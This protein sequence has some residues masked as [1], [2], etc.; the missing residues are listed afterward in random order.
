MILNKEDIEDIYPASYLQQGMIVEYFKNQSYHMINNQLIKQEYDKDKFLEIFRSLVDKHSVLRNSFLIND[1]YGYLNVQHKQIDLENKIHYLTESSCLEKVL[2]EPIDITVAGLYRLIILDN[3]D[4]FEFYFVNH[5]AIEDGWSVASLMSEFINCYINNELAKEEIIP[6]YAKYIAKELSCYNSD[7]HKEFWKNYLSNYEQVNQNLI[8]N[9]KEKSLDDHIVVSRNLNKSLSKNLIKL[10]NS[11]NV[12]IDTIFLMVYQYVLCKLFNID[13]LVTGVT[14]NNRLEEEGGDKV[15]G[16]H[17]NVVPVRFKLDFN[18]TFKA[19]ILSVLDNK[20]LVDKYKLY[21]YGKIKSDLRLEEDIYKCGFNYTHFHIAGNLEQSERGLKVLGYT[22]IPLIFN[23]SRAENLL[24]IS[25]EGASNYID[26]QTINRLVGYIFDLL[27]NLA[28]YKDK[29]LIEYQLLNKE[30]YK[31]IVY[32]WN[33]TDREYP[34]DKTIYELFEEQVEQNPNNVALVYEGQQLTYKELNEKSNQLAR[35]IRK[36]YKEITNQDLVADTLIPLCLDRSL[37]MV[38]G[39]LG[40]MKA[41]GAYVPMDPDYPEERFRHILSDT[42][43]KMVVT[44][45]HL[46]DKLGYIASDINLISIDLD[47][48]QNYVY[49]QEDKSNLE[50]QSKSTDLAYVIYTSGTTGLPKGVLQ[51]HENVHRLLS[52]TDHQFNFNSNDVWTLYHSYIFDFTVWELWGSLIYGGKLIIPSKEIVKDICKFVELCSEYKVSVLNQTPSAFYTFIDQLDSKGNINI[53]RLRYV[54]FGGDALNV[55]HLSKWWTY[56]ESKNFQT[57]LINMYGITE[58]TV[59]VTYKEIEEN[60]VVSSNIGKPIA[61]LKAY[62]LDQYQQPVPV[63]VVGELYIGGAGLARGYLN[64]PELT[65][66]RF[67]ANPFATERDIANGYTRLYKT[68]D[69]VRWLEDGNIE[70][71]GRNDDQVKIR[72]YRIELGEIESQLSKLEGI[73]QSCVLAKERNDNKY[74]VGYYVLSRA[75]LTQEEILK[76]LSKVLPGYMVPSVLVEIDSMPLTVNGKLDR[77]SLPEPEFIN[78]DSYVAPTTEL[79]EELSS[80]FAEVLGLERVGVTDDFFRI[81]GDSIVSIRLVGKLRKSGFNISVADVFNYRT[82]YKLLNNANYSQAILDNKYIPFS[83]VTLEQ[84]NEVVSKLDILERDIEDIYPASYLQTGMLIE[85]ILDPK[86]TYHDVFSYKLNK[87]FDK[88]QF[89]E[90]W[91]KLS[92]K[93]EQLRSSFIELDEGYYNVIHRKICIDDKVIL[94]DPSISIEEIVN[95]EKNIILPLEDCGLYRLIVSERENSFVLIYSFHHAITD[96]WSIASLISEFVDSYIKEE[97]VKQELMSSYGK[98]IRNELAAINN[99]EYRDFWLNYLE[100]YDY[101]NN[102][103]ILDRGSI[104]Q[105]SQIVIDNLIDFNTS[106]KLLE[107]SRELSISVDTIFLTAYYLVLSKL[108]NK[109]D[110]I[111]GRVVNNRL[112]EENGDK[113]FGLHL[114]TIPFRINFCNFKTVKDHIVNIQNNKNQIE[115]YKLYPY[116]KLRSDLNIQEDLY[117]FAFNY[118]HFHIAEGNYKNKDIDSEYS[119]EQTSI[120]LTLNIARGGNDFQIILK[121]LSDFIDKDTAERFVRYFSN[122]LVGLVNNNIL[123]VKDYNLLSKE[124]YKTIVYNWNETDRE[125]PKDKT[126]YELFEEQVEQNPN[127]VALVYE[128]QQLT[129]KELNEKSNQLARYIRKHYKE[130]TNQDLVADTLIPL[131]LDRSLDMVIGILG[132]MKAGGAYVPMDPDYPEERFRHILSDTQAKMVVTQSHLEDKLGYIASD[133]NL[134][135]IDL[136]EEQNYVYAQ[137]DKSNLESQSKS[138]DL[139]Y[140][141][142]T[143]GTT[144]LPKG[145]MVEHKNVN[146]ILEYLT[147]VYMLTEQDKV[148]Q[149][150]SYVFDVSV[151]EVFISLI[152]GSSLHILS[153]EIRIS[154]DEISNYLINN[155]ISYCYLPPVLLSQLPQNS[156]PNIKS[157]VY[158]GEPLDKTIASYWSSRVKLHNIYG[159]TEATI[160]A[161]HKLIK[162]N[163]VEQIGKALSNTKLYI[164][165]QHQQPVP[166]GVVGELYIGGAGLARG[167]LNRPELTAERFIANPFATERDIANG[168]TRLYKTGDL[169]RWLEDGNIEYIGRNDDQVKIRGYRIELGE[170]ESQLSK[171]EGIKQ[172]CVLAKERNDNKYLVGYYVLSRASLTQEEILKQLSKVLPG[173]MVPSVLVEIDSMPLTVNGKLDRK[174]LPEP[175]FINE[176]SYVAPTTELEEE[177]SSIFA[178]VLGLERVGVT[179]DF[180]RIGGN[181]IL[182]IKLSH[183]LSK[184]LDKQISVADVFRTRNIKNLISEFEKLSI[185]KPFYKSYNKN[186]P[187]MLLIHPG[188]GGCEVYNTLVSSLINKYNPIGV[189]NYN[190]YSKNNISSLNKL[191]KYYLNQYLGKYSIKNR[192]INLLGWSLGGQIALEMASILESKGYDNIRVIL[193][194]TILID[195]Q[196]KQYKSSINIDSFKNQRKKILLEEYDHNY[197]NR[198]LEA[199]DVENELYNEPISNKLLKSKIVLLKAKMPDVRFDNDILK[200]LN[201]Y[202]LLL[203]DNNISKIADNQIIK[204][205]EAHH[206]NIIKKI[207]EILEVL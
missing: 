53:S 88:E 149:F 91:K 119:H 51:K 36:H 21:P 100:D 201:N 73:K 172:S 176:D 30:D 171:L 81:G 135:S 167:Y 19:N 182:A 16:L 101:V 32:G 138:T 61:D 46:E 34:K 42:Q 111:I 49:V 129:Y 130:I 86:G 5:H 173:Y 58:T 144:G 87:R 44:Q 28:A 95:K 154:A 139:A 155:E 150:T 166:V 174:S 8:L 84:R 196:I 170:I 143:S 152:Q 116:G 136:D 79:E 109:E 165:D 97:D 161:S 24:S 147:E 77:K 12:P 186:L 183:R 82:I 191:S 37:D 164:L 41:G 6:S 105:E 78:E 85:S 160:Y 126:I 179:D 50:S 20:I 2:R 9:S 189:D 35:Y 102:N 31:T 180:F 26:N 157:F 140:V 151:S 142:Y 60:E 15:F 71:I 66:E 107:L 11:L 90:I 17:L 96:G 128:G 18:K 45:S 75:S 192:P 27:K 184:V 205:I 23:L 64:R 175:E 76:Q 104:S 145:V 181:S 124:E 110:L 59:H 118:V 14:L 163:E 185:I 98:F 43:A 56:K 114:N 153:K 125:Y 62:N 103:L 169:V 133:I 112:Q 158:A 4:E 13:D 156:Y 94:K 38:I 29:K 47:E 194:D 132:V 74:L 197:V 200:K 202:I 57:K 187:D 199:S 22:N 146:S 25:L 162:L 1:K 120:P 121:G 204:N 113:L 206:G 70:Y 92:I 63:G 198:I 99:Q 148:A 83:L 195:K 131:C 141:I 115:R 178:E 7:D 207:D 52:A 54:I 40:V 55:N 177:L 89:I 67:I 48:E 68:G 69:L 159:P 168:Y 72:G 33:Q 193:L 39:I 117:Q 106:T 65:A 190:I 10:S 134:I 80:I 3:K 127:N 188:G 137:E 93:H 123:D 108:L 122:V 203:K